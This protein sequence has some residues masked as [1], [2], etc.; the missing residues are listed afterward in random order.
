MT[1]DR[2]SFSHMK[3]NHKHHIAFA[4]KKRRLGIYGKMKAVIGKILR[5]LCKVKKKEIIKTET[6]PDWI[7]MMVS[8][9]SYLGVAQFVV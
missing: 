4:P 8:I 5:Q 1:N 6:C 7:H 2:K 3:R 9:P